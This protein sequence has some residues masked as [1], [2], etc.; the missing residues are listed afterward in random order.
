MF[1]SYNRKDI[2]IKPIDRIIRI[3]DNNVIVNL[4]N[5]TNPIGLTYGERNNT[6]MRIGGQ[7]D[8]L[9]NFGIDNINGFHCRLIDSDTFEFVSGFSGFRNGNS[10]Y[11][12]MVRKSMCE[13]Y[14]DGDIV[15]IIR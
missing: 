8:S 11:F 15:D 13:K 10:V 12:N 4:G 5:F 2:T 14:S 9:L 3:N 7:A 1:N 6:C